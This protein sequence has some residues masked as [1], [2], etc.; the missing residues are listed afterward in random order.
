MRLLEEQ[1]PM[2]GGSVGLRQ[3]LLCLL[4]KLHGGPQF[5]RSEPSEFEDSTQNRRLRF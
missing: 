5:L 3:T 4:R 2:E 1:D